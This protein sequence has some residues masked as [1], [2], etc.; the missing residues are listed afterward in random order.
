MSVKQVACPICRG[1]GRIYQGHNGWI[2][3]VARC[4]KCQGRGFVRV[5]G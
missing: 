2:P 5:N 3:V 1:K 4:G